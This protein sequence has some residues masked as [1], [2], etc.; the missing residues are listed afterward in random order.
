MTIRWGGDCF[1]LPLAVESALV[2]LLWYVV[3]KPGK[4]AERLQPEGSRG[5]GL[6]P[7]L[8]PARP[9]LRSTLGLGR[10]FQ[11]CSVLP[12]EGGVYLLA[13]SQL[14]MDR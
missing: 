9:V 8:A 5:S 14:L 13:Q 6:G 12:E 11:E 4:E 3:T 2:Q 10:E 7:A 1:E